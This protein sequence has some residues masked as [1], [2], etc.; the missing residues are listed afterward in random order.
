MVESIVEG[1]GGCCELDIQV[2]YFV[3]YNY[4]VLMYKICV[5]AEV[6][7]GKENVVELFI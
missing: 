6:Y 1:M 2:G 4:E 3:L 5:W 7:L